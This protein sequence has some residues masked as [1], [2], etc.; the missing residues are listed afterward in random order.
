MGLSG[1]AG[2]APSSELTNC[3]RRVNISSTE[4]P[5]PSLQL[6]L[7]SFSP[8]PRRPTTPATK[9]LSPEPLRFPWLVADPT[10]KSFDF[11]FFNVFRVVSPFLGGF[12]FSALMV[13]EEMPLGVRQVK[14]GVYQLKKVIT[15]L[16]SSPNSVATSSF[17]MEFGI[18]GFWFPISNKRD[19]EEGGKVAE[20]T[21]EVSGSV[22]PEQKSKVRVF[23]IYSGDEEGIRGGKLGPTEEVKSGE[24]IGVGACAELQF[25]G[26]E[27]F[28]KVRKQRRRIGKGDGIENR[29]VVV[30]EWETPSSEAVGGGGRRGRR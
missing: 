20:S 10:R 30:V 28:E 14:I 17:Q 13:F 4:D 6:A 3:G 22:V 8:I 11:K 18:G 9:A 21:A 15:A 7:L 29:G 27:E 12:L 1:V 26:V 2:T 25:C 16:L 19:L 24:A 5:Q 23:E